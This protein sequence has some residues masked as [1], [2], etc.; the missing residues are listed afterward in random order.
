MAG[1]SKQKEFRK[2]LAEMFAKVLEEK[3]LDWKKGWKGLSDRPVNAARGYPYRSLN[4]FVL[5]IIALERGYTDP[6]WA[7]YNQIQ[8]MGYKLKDAKEMGVR[9]EFWYPYDKEER[10]ALSWEE[11]KRRKASFREERY[12]PLAKYST[13]F[14]AAHIEGLPERVQPQIN[15]VEP[16]ELIHILSENMGVEILNDG[17]DRAFYR[18]KEDKIHLPLPEAFNS[19]EDYNAT[20]L[21]E[22]A[23]ST[24]AAHRLN[25]KLGN[26]FGSPEYAF[27][28]LIAEISSCFM[29]ASLNGE[30]SAFQIE[31]HKAYVQSW[32][33]LIREDPEALVRAIAEAEKAAAYMDYKAG[34]VPEFAYEHPEVL[35]DVKEEAVY[36]KKETALN[37]RL[38]LPNISSFSMDSVSQNEE[39]ASKTFSDDIDRVLE[40]KMI[41]SDLVKA[42]DYT[43][44]ILV[45]NGIL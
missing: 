3:E 27:E 37:E 36:T 33:A 23:H 10:K 1:I 21:H 9:V 7:T 19:S 30:P 43:P 17:G 25:R 2:N 29:T 18:P 45:K 8:Q 24:G 32:A 38:Q 26:G 31:N 40:N 44:D 20:A 5:Q 34:L 39:V 16:D 11:F 6:R 22:L 28:E 35:P 4:E 14:N 42:R 13:V 12:I 41:S 15:E